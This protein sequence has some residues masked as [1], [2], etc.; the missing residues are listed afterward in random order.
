MI[1]SITEAPSISDS[2][3]GIKLSLSD[4][5]IFLTYQEAERVANHINALLQ[6]AGR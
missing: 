5:K 1:I 6:E 4:C 3:Q 2:G